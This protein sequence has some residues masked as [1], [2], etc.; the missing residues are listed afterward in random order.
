MKMFCV[1]RKS[2]ASALALWLVVAVIAVPVLACA[3]GTPAA[4]ESIESTTSCCGDAPRACCDT[5]SGQS[6]MTSSASTAEQGVT[7][8]AARTSLRPGIPS[9]NFA[10]QTSECVRKRIVPLPLKREG[11]SMEVL[12]LPSVGGVSAVL[13]RQN[14]LEAPGQRV[15]PEEVARRAATLFYLDLGMMR[16]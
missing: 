13:A 4:L 10:A 15:V 8:I 1:A 9:S 3:C 5:P 6:A 2:V 12:R 14:S 16:C 11:I 7:H